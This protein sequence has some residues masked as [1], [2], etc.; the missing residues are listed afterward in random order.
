MRQRLAM[1]AA[2][3]TGTALLVAAVLFALARGS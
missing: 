3:A 2:G 1:H